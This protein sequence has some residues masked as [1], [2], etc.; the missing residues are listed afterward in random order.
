MRREKNHR[1]A[2][3]PALFPWVRP[4]MLW[5]I[6][7]RNRRRLSEAQAQEGGVSCFPRAGC[8]LKYLAATGL[9]PTAK[10]RPEWA[11]RSCAGASLY[12]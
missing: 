12:G 9:P 4:L 3:D 8:G 11:A 10:D 7:Q 1:R 5:G 2:F 6:F